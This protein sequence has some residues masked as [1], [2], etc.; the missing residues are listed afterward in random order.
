MKKNKINDN[1]TFF[2]VSAILSGMWTYSQSHDRTVLMI[3][4]LCIAVRF[5]RLVFCGKKYLLIISIFLISC[6]IDTERFAQMQS[7][8][9]SIGSS[10]I[11]FYDLLK[12]I[13]WFALLLFL[14]SFSIETAESSR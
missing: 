2:S 10:T 14:A 6:I 13:T 5:G 11:L 12:Y 8:V 4:I 3:V 1:L 9:I 7:C